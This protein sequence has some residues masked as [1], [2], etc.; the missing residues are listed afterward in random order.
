MT[1][2]IRNHLAPFFAP[3]RVCVKYFST[4]RALNDYATHI[5]ILIGLAKL[6]EIHSVLEFGCGRY[7]TLTFL[8]ASAFPRLERLH[9]IEN[10]DSWAATI[11]EAAKD[12]HRWRLQLVNGEIAK[13]I[14]DLNLEAFDLILIDDS[15]TSA[16]RAATIR[17]IARK[18]PQHPW[19]V[20]HDF[21]VEEYRQ[22]ATGFKHRHRFRAYNPETGVVANQIN[23]WKIIDRVI[24]SK[25]KLLAPDAIAQWIDSFRQDLQD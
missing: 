13:S 24:K 14:A 15:K 7:S 12:D 1:V 22:A 19:I 3:L 4:P 17:A 23:D 2:G 16:Q 25:A 21:E 20:I 9:S 6:R 5:P 8:N 18:Q 11:Q 10:D